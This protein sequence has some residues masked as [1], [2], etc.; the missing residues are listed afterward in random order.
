[1]PAMD[2]D[3]ISNLTVPSAHFD[4]SMQAL[5]HGKHIFIAKP[6]AEPA[7][8]SAPDTFPG[9]AGRIA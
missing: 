4:I 7:L 2:V 8:G 3:P 9:T 1:M 5:S 6:L